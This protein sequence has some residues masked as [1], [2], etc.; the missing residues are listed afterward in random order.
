MGIKNNLK[1]WQDTARDAG[2][3]IKFIAW[4]DRLEMVYN[5]PFTIFTGFGGALLFFASITLVMVKGFPTWYLGF[6][7]FGIFMGIMGRFYAAWH[8]YHRWPSVTA[9]VLDK[10]IRDFQVP[11]KGM[12]GMRTIWSFRV[13]CEFNYQGRTYQVTPITTNIM[14]FRSK[15][16][17]EKYLEETITLSQTCTI[18]INPDN[19]L[20]SC[21]HTRP[22]I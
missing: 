20:Q 7:G 5:T 14:D 18:W 22:K 17:L 3:R 12:V 8:K 2:W 10:E 19:V 6:A 13:L 1:K 11:K 9:Q 16:A 15:S 4:Q 21:F